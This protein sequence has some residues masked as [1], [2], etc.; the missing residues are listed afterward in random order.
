MTI[1]KSYA[2][3]W[4]VLSVPPKALHEH[5]CLPTAEIKTK[6][7]GLKHMTFYRGCLTIARGI[8]IAFTIHELP[9]FP[10]HI[11]IA[12][13][14]YSLLCHHYST[15]NLFFFSLHK[16]FL[17]CKIFLKWAP[18]YSVHAP[19]FS[20]LLPHLSWWFCQPTL[21]KPIFFKCNLC[22]EVL[23]FDGTPFSTKFPFYHDTCYLHVRFFFF[24]SFFASFPVDKKDSLFT[25]SLQ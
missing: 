15:T 2:C 22:G 3:G 23:K 21:P 17:S 7:T 19:L 9:F 5:Y 13:L 12:L 10:Y 4:F 24:S 11:L 20:Q 6:V 1:G 14:F 8:S 18:L 25:F 16:L